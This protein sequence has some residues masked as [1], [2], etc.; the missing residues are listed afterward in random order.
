MHLKL[1]AERYRQKARECAEAARL[2]SGV[3]AKTLYLHLEQDWLLLADQAE[4]REELDAAL[5]K[6]F[7]QER[8]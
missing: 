3:D 8:E 4:K 7:H 6:R 2:C 5:S 1:Q